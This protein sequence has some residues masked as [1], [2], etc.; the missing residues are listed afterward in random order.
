MLGLYIARR[1]LLRSWCNSWRL[2]RKC[3]FV[4]Q[5]KEQEL[6]KLNAARVSVLEVAS[7][8]FLLLPVS[9]YSQNVVGTF[10][11]VETLYAS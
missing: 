2:Q 9:I 4:L 10:V 8:L 5:E 6:Q 7:L 1:W 11:L 3:T